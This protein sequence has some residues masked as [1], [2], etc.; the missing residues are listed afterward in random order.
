MRHHDV[1]PTSRARTAVAKF[2]TLQVQAIVGFSS[3]GEAP[4]ACHPEILLISYNSVQDNNIC[5]GSTT[6]EDKFLTKIG[7]L[8]Q[9]FSENCE[10]LY[11]VNPHADYVHMEKRHRVGVANI[12]Y[13]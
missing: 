9:R 11:T 4:V 7:L 3:C 8:S 10:L 6:Y 5:I 2:S 13:T 1:R 12:L